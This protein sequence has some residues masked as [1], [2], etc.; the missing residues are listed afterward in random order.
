MG[1]ARLSYHDRSGAPGRNLPPALPRV[2]RAGQQVLERVVDA[3]RPEIRFPLERPPDVAPR[4]GVSSSSLPN[5][6]RARMKSSGL[7]SEYRI[8]F[9]VTVTV[10][11]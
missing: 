1:S 11:P 2:L 5:R 8:S 3:R 6:T 10:V 9:F 4:A 7:F